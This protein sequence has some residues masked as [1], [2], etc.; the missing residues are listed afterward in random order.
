MRPIFAFLNEA[1]LD[2]I[3][4]HI[5]ATGVK[6][7]LIFNEEAFKALAPDRAGA[8]TALVVPDRVLAFEPLE[9]EG[10]S[11]DFGNRYEEVEVGVHEAVVVKEETELSFA[12][13]EQ[14]FKSLKII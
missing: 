5:T 11:P 10:E 9:S 13:H 3:L 2:W 8:V 14:G 4:F 7:N 6:I 1:C 12:F